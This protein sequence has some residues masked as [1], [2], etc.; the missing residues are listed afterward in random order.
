M[1]STGQIRP[2]NAF[3]EIDSPRVKIA[4]GLMLKKLYADAGR[5]FR[6]R[7]RRPDFV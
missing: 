3:K 5:F 4:S 1:T 6:T 2:E 7:A